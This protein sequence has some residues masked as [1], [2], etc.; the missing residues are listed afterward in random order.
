MASAALLAV[1]VVGLLVVQPRTRAPS[2]TLPTTTT[3]PPPPPGL[4]VDAS[5]FSATAAAAGAD[6]IRWGPAG[7]RALLWQPVVDGRAELTGLVPNTRYVA[8]SGDESVTFTTPAVPANLSATVAAGALRL[9]GAPFFP[10]IAWKECPDRWTADLRDGITLFAGNPCT[11]LASLLTDTAGRAVVAGTTEDVA[12]TTGPG[13]IG[14]FYPDEADARGY[15]G[16]TLASAGP[17][18]RFLTITSHFF[19][20]AAPLPA[21]RGM[22]DGLVRRADVVG[23]DLYPLQ[24]LCRPELLPWVYDAQA[25]LRELARP[26]ATFQWIEDRE[27]NCPDA[28]DAVTPAT[29]RVESWLA[30]A[31]GA[32]GLGFFP[33]NWDAAVGNTIRGIARRVRALLPALV[34]PPVA[35]GASPAVPGVRTS[36]R[37]FGGAFYVIAVNAG[38]QAASV[39]LRANELGDRSFVEAGRSALLRAHDGAL[40]IALPAMSARIYVAPPQH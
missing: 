21:G 5:A 15:T 34:Q 30:I 8:T 14:W 9:G 10:L 16:R 1:F 11:N 29:I 20:L 22:Y 28:A 18:V 33:G 36:G 26:R 12:G 31:G 6:A 32:T 2:P 39:T 19:P 35:I 37:T 40:A 3:R 7:G 24:E 4:S 23:F 17:G 38:A 27:L 13:L 25:S